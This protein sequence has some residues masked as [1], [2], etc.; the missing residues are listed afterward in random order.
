MSDGETP[1]DGGRVFKT[2]WLPKPDDANT[3]T[4]DG[5]KTK[6]QSKIN[7]LKDFADAM[8]LDMGTTEKVK[9]AM[10]NGDW[11]GILVVVSVEISEYLGRQT[12]PVNKMVRQK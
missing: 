3:M 6:R 12:N 7:M 1:I 2:L 10:N 11:I 4:S 5:K 9:E 8:E